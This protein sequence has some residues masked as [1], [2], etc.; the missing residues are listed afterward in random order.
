VRILG[1]RDLF[2]TSG[3]SVQLKCVVSQAPEPPGYIEWRRNDEIVVATNGGGGGAGHKVR[4]SRGAAAALVVNGG[5]RKS[6]GRVQVGKLI[7]FVV[8]KCLFK[9][10][11]KLF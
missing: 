8:T 11:N 4:H 7:F 10:L 9:K 3:T 5:W 2:V 6:G 1:E